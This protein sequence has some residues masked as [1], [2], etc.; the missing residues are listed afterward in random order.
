MPR[1]R[2]W[3]RSLRDTVD[4]HR[5]LPFDWGRSD[6]FTFPMD[7]VAAMTGADPSDGARTWSDESGAKRALVARGFSS[8]ADAF[9]S[10]FAEISPGLARRGD[11]VAFAYDGAICG[12]ICLGSSCVGKGVGGLVFVPRT[13]AKRAFRVD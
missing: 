3:E 7:C 8:V 11:L 9:A 12:G 2:N 6:C 4:Q 10:A 1:L 13:L 5:A